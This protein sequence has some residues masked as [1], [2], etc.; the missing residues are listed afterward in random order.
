[1]TSSG[2][3]DRNPVERQRQDLALEQTD[4][5]GQRPNPAQ[6]RG[7]VTHRFG[8]RQLED[9][10]PDE[11]RQHL[12]GRPARSIDRREVELTPAGVADLAFLDRGDPGRAQKAFDC[13]RRRPDAGPAP[14]LGAIRLSRGNPLGNDRETA[15]RYIPAHLGR[16]DLGGG[17]LVAQQPGEVADRAALHSR[18]NLLRQQLEQ[19]LAAALRR[20][21]RA[22][23]SHLTRPATFRSM[24][25]RAP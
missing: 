12:G 6:G 13:R 19:Q 22:G 24:P 9:R 14:L 20:D 15:R 11:L 1:M 3:S 17:E 2:P 4:D 23:F 8:P 7:R 21:G 18:R 5:R 16:R 10:R 25:W